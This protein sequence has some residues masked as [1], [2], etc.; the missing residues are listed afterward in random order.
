MALRYLTTAEAAKAIGVSPNTVRAW[1]DAD[2]DPLPAFNISG[3]DD[4]PRWRINED[5]LRAYMDKR[6][7]A[8]G[9]AA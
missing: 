8:A 2:A 7:K 3:D 5:H 1:I 6:A 4:K 9:G